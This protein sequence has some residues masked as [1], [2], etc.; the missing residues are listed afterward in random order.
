M[1]ALNRREFL[2]ATTAAAATLAAGLHAAGA[3]EPARERPPVKLA[4]MG[5][6]SRGKQLLP[7]FLSF[8]EVEITYLCDPD[9]D[10]I[11]AAMKIVQDKGQ[12]TT[13]RV[14]RDFRKAHGNW[15]GLEDLRLTD[16]PEVKRGLL[17]LERTASTF[18]AT[19]TPPKEDKARRWHISADGRIWA[20]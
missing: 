4:L 6:H 14:E 15:G 16:L 11:P 9:D 19:L 18:E 8:P 1:T 10:T 17:K 7:D 20:D 2:G 13:P 3:D 5:V 12:Q